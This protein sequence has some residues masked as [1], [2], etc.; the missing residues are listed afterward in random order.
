MA[1]S[2]GLDTIPVTIAN[3]QSI[4][5]EADLGAK[6]LV[7]IAMPAAWTAAVLTFQVTIDNGAT[8]LE[9]T[10]SAGA[11]FSFTVAAG[12]FIAVDPALWRGINAI[13]IRSGTSGTPVA[14]G[15]DRVLNLILRS[16]A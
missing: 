6:T 7:G 14:Q 16:V 9:A 4:S 3:G 2:I 12:Q 5:A 10:T 8:W 13:K 1:L 11:A 15:S